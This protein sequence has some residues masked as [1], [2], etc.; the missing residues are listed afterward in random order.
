M[1]SSSWT[2]SFSGRSEPAQRAALTVGWSLADALTAAGYR[3]V[4]AAGVEEARP[5]LAAE[6]VACVLLDVRLKDGDG[7]ALLGDARTTS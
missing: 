1:R 4:E 6:P 3:P 2:H 5:A 7:L